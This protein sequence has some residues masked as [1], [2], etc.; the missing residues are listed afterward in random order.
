MPL[1]DGAVGIRAVRSWERVMSREIHF[2]RLDWG[3]IQTDDVGRNALVEAQAVLDFL[4]KDYDPDKS[5]SRVREEDWL[6]ICRVQEMVTAMQA[7]EAETRA[8]EGET[9]DV[10]DRRSLPLPIIEWAEVEREL[11][12]QGFDP[13]EVVAKAAASLEAW[14][15][16]SEEDRKNLYVYPSLESA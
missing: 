8:A 13:K 5:R 11:V 3:G 16:L 9:G 4:H 1:A 14:S 12:R 2:V 6:A 10:P 7:R 15:A